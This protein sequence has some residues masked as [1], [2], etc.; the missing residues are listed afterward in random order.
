[1]NSNYAIV[2]RGDLFI[3]NLK[4]NFELLQGDHPVIILSSKENNR[5]SDLITICPLTS[6][7]KVNPF[8]IQITGCGLRKTSVALCNQIRCVSKADL[9]IKIGFL[10]SERLNLVFKTVEKYFGI[11]NDSLDFVY[12]L[13]IENMTK[14]ITE[15]TNLRGRLNLKDKEL[16]DEIRIKVLEIK[17]YC[18]EENLNN[19]NGGR[20]I[21]MLIHREKIR[22]A[23]VKNDF[24]LMAELCEKYLVNINCMD[25][26]GKKEY[27]ELQW[28]NYNLAL[29][30]SEI[31]GK[32]ELSYNLAKKAIEYCGERDS[33]YVANAWLIGED[34]YKLNYIQ[35]AVD[36]F[37][38]CIQY[39]ESISENNFKLIAIFNKER[40]L[41]NILGM[42]DCIERYKKSN[43]KIT[44]DH[45]GDME[46]TKIVEEMI[47]DLNKI[48]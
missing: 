4:G 45:I 12:N 14:S 2:K 13:K 30:F 46:H 48:L 47:S 36:N 23:K 29:A 11:K 31:K 34:A 19:F 21:Q 33:I 22:E 10:G 38:I 26:T 18:A 15:L 37:E 20:N 7:Q 17:A 28:V 9:G 5:S 42:R 44:V 16:N 3:C 35:E 40:A 32:I 41:K 39:Y 24:E 43:L 6:K 27:E 8:N 1:M 25:L